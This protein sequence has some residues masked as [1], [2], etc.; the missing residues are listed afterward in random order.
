MTNDAVPTCLPRHLRAVFDRDVAQAAADE[1]GFNCGP[2][3]L[4]AVLRKTP[5]QIRPHLLDFEKKGYTNPKLMADIL[6]GLEVPFRRVMG[7]GQVGRHGFQTPRYPAFGLVKI[8]WEG[9]WTKPQVP[10]RAAYRHTHWIGYQGEQLK[11]PNKRMVFDINAICDGGWIPWYEWQDALV[12]WLLKR[13]EPKATG[14]WWP[15]HCW[16]IDRPAD[17]GVGSSQA[18]ETDVLV[19]STSNPGREGLR[20]Q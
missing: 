20:G 9:P 13:V 16:E 10:V 18:P 6:H 8:Q 14:G 17:S 12:P 3:A 5:E 1:W 19:L 15:T 11:P 7:P 2:G 4:C